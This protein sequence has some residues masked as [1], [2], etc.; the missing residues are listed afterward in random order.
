MDPQKMGRKELIL[1]DFCFIPD[2]DNLNAVFVWLPNRSGKCVIIDMGI[3][4]A[5]HTS[6]CQ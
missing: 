2:G 1:A 6:K 3:R 5:T 4:S